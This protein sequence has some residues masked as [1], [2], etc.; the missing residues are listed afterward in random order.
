[1]ASA[2]T[3]FPLPRD[4]KELL[5]PG[6][7]TTR[8]APACINLWQTTLRSGRLDTFIGIIDTQKWICYLAPCFGIV[9]S[10]PKETFKQL[11]DF[12][13]A[14]RDGV[15]P[16]DTPCMAN[17]TSAADKTMVGTPKSELDH[18]YGAHGVC[19]VPLDKP[20]FDGY[21]HKAMHRW[22]VRY[23]DD[24]VKWERCLGFAIQRD[25]TGYYIRHASTLNE[26]PGQMRESIIPTFQPIKP[27]M[28]PN[29]VCCC[30]PWGQVPYVD[31]T[32]EPRDL[33]TEWAR[34]LEG[35]L[36]RDLGIRITITDLMQSRGEHQLSRRARFVPV[37]APPAAASSVASSASAASGS[38]SGA[39]IASSSAV[40]S[41]ALAATPPVLAPPPPPPPSSVLDVKLP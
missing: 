17:S 1:M 25:A 8:V 31:K 33:P 30:I 20:S 10:N 41:A 35:V 28:V 16:P 24:S 37:A 9:V 38:G 6:A 15:F 5:G 32:I 12:Y 22:V 3:I 19:F 2:A 27:L 4:P 29:Y 39:A 18:I 14:V 34:L 7:G 36:E 40:A 21:S 23:C 26:F 11:V 13:N